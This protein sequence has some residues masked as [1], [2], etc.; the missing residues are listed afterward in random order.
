MSKLQDIITQ[1]NNRVAE[2]AN[3][4]HPVDSLPLNYEQTTKQQI[5]DLLFEL[6]GEDEVDPTWHLQSKD[7]RLKEEVRD[8]LRATLRAKVQDL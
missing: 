2:Y 4:N 3:A 5:K 7:S 6:I 8:E 1:S